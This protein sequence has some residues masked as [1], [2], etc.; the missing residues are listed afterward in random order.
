MGRD[1]RRVGNP[2]GIPCAFG[3]TDTAPRRGGLEK[4]LSCFHFSFMNLDCSEPWR[5]LYL[6]N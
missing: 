2:R 1:A 3:M 6:F 5:A 4:T